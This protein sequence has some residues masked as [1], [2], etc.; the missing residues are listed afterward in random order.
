MAGYWKRDPAYIPGADA[1]VPVPLHVARHRD[2][3][4]NQAALLAR[5]L[6][7]GVGLPVVE[8]GLTRTRAT[9]PQVG[10]SIPERE[11]N[12]SGAFECSADSLVGMK[13]LLVDDVF[14]TGCT[15][16]AACSALKDAGASSVWA[17]TLA[18]A[19]PHE[20]LSYDNP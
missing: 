17:Y 12:V 18:R 6:G 15:L 11:A 8:D 10:L 2:R 9:A 14:T 1:I 5:E 3:G 19:R 13:V 16:G 20:N 7:A 4:Y